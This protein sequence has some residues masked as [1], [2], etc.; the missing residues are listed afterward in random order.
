M[1]D[2][3]E[4]LL[5][6]LDAEIDAAEAGGDGKTASVLKAVRAENGKR[7]VENRELKEKMAQALADSEA[8]AA[9]AAS[10]GTRSSQLQAELE[11]E[12]ADRQAVL[13]RLT[14]ANKT[15]ID[16]LPERLR[17][18]VP[19]GLGPVELREWLDAAVPVLH[20]PPPAPLDGA[21]GSKADRENATVAVDEDTATIAKAL[22]VDPQALA[23]R[24]KQDGNSG[25]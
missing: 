7:R 14:A 23:K 5:Q 4:Q 24:V 3:T 18:I 16:G 22:G 11:K 13:D 12:R 10:E 6:Q 2:E 25:V 1:S 17:P 21:A 19:Q 9:K 20:Q 8:A 15:V